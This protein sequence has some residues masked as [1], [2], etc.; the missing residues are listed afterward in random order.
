[1]KKIVSFLSFILIVFLL[2]SCNKKVVFDQKV[3]FPNANWAFE[4][5]AIDFE[6][7]FTG[8]DKPY[9]VVLELEL[10]GTPNVDQIFTTFSILSPS[11]GETVKSIFFNFN[12]PQEPY[13]QGTSANEKIYKMTV[14][15]K[16]YFTETGKYKF[17][18]DQYSSNAD[19][20]NI[21]SLRMYVEKKKE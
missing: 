20:Y 10:I 18:V 4:Y 7:P 19:N 1:M 2:T 9:A 11:G 14:Y 15:P 13:I 3:L 16:R 21:Q 17:I 12:N 8:S 6:I 5:K